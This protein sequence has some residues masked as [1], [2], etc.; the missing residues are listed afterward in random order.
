MTK[1]SE[2]QDVEIE[3]A[4]DIGV[5]LYVGKYQGER[6]VW[7]LLSPDYKGGFFKAKPEHNLTPTPDS[8]MTVFDPCY[9]YGCSFSDA[10]GSCVNCGDYE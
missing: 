3:V 4:E 7:H 10:D 5:V 6:N 8:D 1:Y 2:I 9:W